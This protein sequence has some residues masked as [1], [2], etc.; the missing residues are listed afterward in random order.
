MLPAIVKTQQT[1]MI[2]ASSRMATATGR[3]MMMSGEYEG[4]MRYGSDQ[5]EGRNEESN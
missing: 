5:V 1:R 2:P 3:R 4:W